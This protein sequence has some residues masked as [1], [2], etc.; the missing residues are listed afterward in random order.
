MDELC[1]WINNH[2]LIAFAVVAYGFTW[3]LW[4]LMMTLV[5]RFN[6][7]RFLFGM[8]P[9]PKAP[10]VQPKEA[11]PPSRAGRLPSP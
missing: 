3:G 6:L 4:V 11:V 9:L 8:K 7:L 5:R 10:A 1:A 2:P